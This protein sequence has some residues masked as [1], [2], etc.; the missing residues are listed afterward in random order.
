MNNIK[1]TFLFSLLLIVS[2]SLI[3]LS[4]FAINSGTLLK[5]VQ[6]RDARD[7][8]VWIPYFGK[9]VLIILYN[10]VDVADQ[11]DPFANAVKAAKIPHTKIQPIGIANMKD[12]PWKPN[13]VIRY[14][15]RRKIKQYPGTV[16]LT[17]PKYILRDAWGLGNCNQKSVLILI[18][19]DKKVHY[20]KKGKL[21]TGESKKAL[22]IIKK[23]VQ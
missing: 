2:V 22:E 7:N 23:L 16:I 5:N 20:Y 15:A 19:K 11:N 3:S 17:D 4:A 8:P 9:K 6:V 13:T 12:A 10:D 18:G 21:T 14:M 1:K